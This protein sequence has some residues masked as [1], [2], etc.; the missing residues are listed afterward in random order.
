[1]RLFDAAGAVGCARVSILAAAVAPLWIP[2][3]P[4]APVVAD[5]MQTNLI[6]TAA[7]SP[8]FPVSSYA[9]AS[10]LDALSKV[11]TFGVEK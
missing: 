7:P 4:K 9:R 6:F 5:G 2:A 1:M 8:V 3:V 11:L 10:S